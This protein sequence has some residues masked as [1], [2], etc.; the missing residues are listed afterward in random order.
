MRTRTAL[1]A[2]L[3]LTASVLQ[4]PVLAESEPRAQLRLIVVDQANAALPAAAVT[5]Y[6]V[7]GNPGMDVTADANG[8]VV[9]PSLPVGFA[10]ICGRERPFRPMVNTGSGQT[11]HVRGS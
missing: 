7:D 11:T 8:V 4:V 6:T 1:A 3:L 9:V 10:Q 5:I 2:L